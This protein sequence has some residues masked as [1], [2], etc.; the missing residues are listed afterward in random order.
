MALLVAGLL[1]CLVL[2]ALSGAR[3]GRRASDGA[4]S[5][6]VSHNPADRAS[7]PDAEEW[8]AASCRFASRQVLG[9][10]SIGG[11]NISIEM[12]AECT[13]KRRFDVSLYR[14]DGGVELVGTIEFMR[15]GFTL[16]TWSNVGPGT[17]RFVLDKAE[18][19]AVVESS[20]VVVRGW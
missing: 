13:S 8:Y 17:Y 5:A 3:A 1:L 15:D 2:L 20:S 10:F 19:G 11:N 12:T 14:A 16:G 9:D 18:D 4:V 6:Q 7:L